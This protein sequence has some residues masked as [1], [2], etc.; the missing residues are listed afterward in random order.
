MARASLVVTPYSSFFGGR[1][2]ENWLPRFESAP[3]GI[4]RGAKETI[5]T[6]AAANMIDIVY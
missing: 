6:T 5:S 1:R 4:K 2:Q 3:V